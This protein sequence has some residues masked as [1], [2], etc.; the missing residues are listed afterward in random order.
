MQC[1]NC[2]KPATFHQTMIVH[3]EKQELHLCEECAE[4]QRGLK[5]QELNLPAILQNLVGQQLGPLTE[6]LVRLTCPCCGIQYMEFRAEGRLGC[7]HDYEVFRLGLEPLL[8]RI[9]RNCRHAGKAP[10]RRGPDHGRS[11]ELMRLRRE[12]Q[13]AVEAEAFE[14]AARLRDVIRQKEA[15]DERG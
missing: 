15:A 7:P 6:A 1:Q 12:L 9:H 4:K 10:R 5:N 3:G 11:V 8:R 14:E 2:N 13:T